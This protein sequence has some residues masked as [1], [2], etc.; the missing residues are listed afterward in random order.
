MTK[1]RISPAMKLIEF[2]H[3]NKMKKLPWSRERAEH[4]DAWA[5][6]L[7]VRGGFEF[8]QGDFGEPTSYMNEGLYAAAILEGNMSAIKA[9]EYAANRKPFIARNVTPSSEG[10]QMAHMAGTRDECRLAVGFSFVWDGRSVT[11]T[12]FAKDSSYVRACAYPGNAWHNVPTCETCGQKRYDLYKSTANKPER[13]YKITVDEL[14][15]GRADHRKKHPKCKLCLKPIEEGKEVCG[16]E[17]RCGE[18]SCRNKIKSTADGKRVPNPWGIRKQVLMCNEC[19]KK[20][21]EQKGQRGI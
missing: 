19:I 20:R 12:S 3:A 18:F 15:E 16:E 14:R 5:L 1:K 13:V 4:I 7:A 2:V 10:R 9:M 11:V 6:E 17:H 21:E 8:L